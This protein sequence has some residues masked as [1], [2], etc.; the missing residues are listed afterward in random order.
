MIGRRLK[1]FYYGAMAYPMRA[2]AWAYRRFRAPR[3]GQVKVHLGPGQTNYLDG[4]INVDANRVSARIDV[5]ANLL[6]GL[7]FRDGTVDVFY[8][9]HVIEHLPDHELPGHFREMYRCLKPGGVIRVGGPNG[10]SAAK[11]LL[12][13]DA[14]W[15]GD[16]PDKR[17]SIGGRFANFILCRGEHLT[18]LTESY[19]AEIAA[20]A[21]FA[22][23]SPCRP[24]TETGYPH[25]IDARVLDKEDRETFDLPHTLIVEARK[26]S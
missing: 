4:W 15:F 26:P 13:G 11:K 9:H 8:S 18:I 23:V 1:A 5:W 25:L 12:E 2:N 20:G 7:P 22:D 10:E 17:E 6:D 19:L 3:R 24:R 16:F 14:A 21:G